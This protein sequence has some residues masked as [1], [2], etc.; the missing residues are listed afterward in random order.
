M[1]TDGAIEDAV[2]KMMNV[3][4][5][6]IANGSPIADEWSVSVSMSDQV[7][8]RIFVKEHIFSKYVEK[9]ATES[10]IVKSLVSFIFD[11]IEDDLCDVQVSSKM[12]S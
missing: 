11:L 9:S 5:A 12:V 1:T 10:M 4:K 8:Y 7:G 2:L 3:R 6:A